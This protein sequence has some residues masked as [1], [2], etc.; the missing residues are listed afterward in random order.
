MDGFF[1]DLSNKFSRL[2]EYLTLLA[3]KFFDVNKLK[4]DE[5]LAVI[6]STHGEGEPPDMAEDFYSYI[7]GK[8]ASK[9]DK[10]KFSVLAL[11]DKSYRFFCKTGEDI[12]AVFT[13]LGAENISPIVKCDVDFE[14]DAENWMND[15]LRNLTPSSELLKHCTKQLWTRKAEVGT[16]S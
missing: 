7:T 8:R 14:E 15:F 6:V 12:D 5:N 16:S 13:K 9:L 1:Q 3:S 4:E 10:L 11:G 2:V